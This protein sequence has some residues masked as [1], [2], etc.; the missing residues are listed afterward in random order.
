[1]GARDTAARHGQWPK[2]RHSNKLNMRMSANTGSA[3]ALPRHNHATAGPPARNRA[4]STAQHFNVLTIQHFCV[5]TLRRFNVLTL[6]TV[7]TKSRPALDPRPS[8]LDVPHSSAD[9]CKSDNPP[10]R[11]DNQPIQNRNQYRQFAAIRA[12]WRSL[13]A[14]REFCQNRL[15]LESHT[16]SG[17]RK[18]TEA[19]WKPIEG[20][21]A[22]C[23]PRPNRTLNRNLNPNLGADLLEPQPPLHHSMTPPLHHPAITPPP[24]LTPLRHRVAYRRCLTSSLHTN[25]RAISRKPL[26]S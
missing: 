22:L 23:V 2:L 7:L 14:F 5:L 8:A 1:M 9:A 17:T 26:R 6:L 20:C 24:S 19:L 18:R 16:T 4:V 13:A 3:K 25:L 12:Y 11:T 10:I 15:F 21:V